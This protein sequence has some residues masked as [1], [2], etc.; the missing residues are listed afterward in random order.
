MPI[1]VQSTMDDSWQ[2]AGAGLLLTSFM[3]SNEL[4]L[5]ME[6]ARAESGAGAGDQG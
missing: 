4:S 6:R 3:S 1:W 5:G 2:L